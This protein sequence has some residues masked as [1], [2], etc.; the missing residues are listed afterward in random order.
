MKP[1][2]TQYLIEAF[3][4]EYHDGL[5]PKFWN[6]N[7]LKT[8]IRH[9]LLKVAKVYF[10]SL[11]LAPDYKITDI[12]MTGSLANY[13]YTRHSDIDVHVVIDKNADQCDD[14]GLDLTDALKAKNLV[15]NNDHEISVLGYPVEVYTQLA[16]EEHHST[17]VYS[18]QDDKWIIQP[19]R[20]KGI[21][22]S[23][24]EYAVN[25]KAKALKEMIDSLK[26]ATN[27]KKIKE[28]RKKIKSMR[29]AG[30]EKGGEFSVENLVF[31]ELRNTNYLDKLQDYYLQAFDKS[32]SLK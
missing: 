19:S 16:D 11:D 1:T 2:L 5:N 31:K 20:K 12:V 28:L 24:N 26:D 7:S 10:E 30:L 32:L 14:C 18:L 23:V 9:H 21:E 4:F 6:G 3:Q 17:G 8:K 13:N 15:W 27:Y 22:K 29:Q 25:V